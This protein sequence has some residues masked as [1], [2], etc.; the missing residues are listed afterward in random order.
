MNIS[1]VEHKKNEFILVFGGAYH[2][3]FNF[4]FNIAEAIN[5]GTLHWL[6]DVP[7]VKYCK[8]EKSSVKVNLQELRNNL[9]AYPQLSKSKEFK[10]FSARIFESESKE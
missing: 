3:G 2:S 7:D 10:V 4:G 6:Q 9:I 8:C 1:K 5:Y